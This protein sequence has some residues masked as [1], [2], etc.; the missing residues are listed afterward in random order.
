MLQEEL[1][2]DH[3]WT[4]ELRSARNAAEARLR[5]QDRVLAALYTAR[6]EDRRQLTAQAEWLV[7]YVGRLLAAEAEVVRLQAEL[8]RTTIMP[9][10]EVRYE[11][12]FPTGPATYQTISLTATVAADED[13]QAVLDGLRAVVAAHDPELLDARAVVA[14]PAWYPAA[15][16]QEARAR[17]G[18]LDPPP[19]AVASP[20]DDGADAA[21][22]PGG[23]PTGVPEEG[24]IF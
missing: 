1:V 4:A 2:T 23:E 7:E 9:I 16:V 3:G 19:A 24:R 22:Q 13:A 6:A 15:R 17:L 10:T 20:R 14:H 12:R 18:L 21:Y 11:Q 8:E 5:A